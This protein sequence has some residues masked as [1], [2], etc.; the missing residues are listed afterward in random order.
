M[1]NIGELDVF[2]Q[3]RQ[4]VGTLSQA[5][6]LSWPGEI[7]A[8]RPGATSDQQAVVSTQVGGVDGFEE[9]IQQMDLL[10]LSV[11]EQS[12]VGGLLGKY[13]SLDR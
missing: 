13:R 8:T 1:V 7:I 3:P 12:Q 2:L 9:V 6:P 5:Q 10:H 4:V 11:E